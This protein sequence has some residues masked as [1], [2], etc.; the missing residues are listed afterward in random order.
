MTTYIVYRMGPAPRANPENRLDGAWII[1]RVCVWDSI[2]R[3]K[4]IVARFS[5]DGRDACERWAHKHGI[6]FN[7]RIEEVR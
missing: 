7:V 4:R 2:A 1:R 6:T 3:S 5:T